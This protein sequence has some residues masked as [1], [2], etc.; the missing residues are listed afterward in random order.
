MSK[1]SCRECGANCGYHHESV[2]SIV[3]DDC[4]TGRTRLEREN[5]RLRAELREANEWRDKLA[6]KIEEV[7]K[8]RDEHAKAPDSWRKG[9]EAGVHWMTAGLRPDFKALLKRLD[10][11][12]AR[13]ARTPHPE[14]KP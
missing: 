3:C 6:A 1:L 7:E 12:E 4:T 5:E 9:F 13:V 14:H 2:K 10:R 11:A 8:E